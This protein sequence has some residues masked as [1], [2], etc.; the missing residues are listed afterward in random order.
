MPDAQVDPGPILLVGAGW[1]G[2]PLAI[3][4]K[5]LGRKIVVT[6]RRQERI[7]ALQANGLSC[8]RLDLD[9]SGE[10]MGLSDR[11][12]PFQTIIWAV[13]PG[14]SSG[15]SYAAQL[16]LLLQNWPAQSARKLVFYS[17]TGVYPESAGVWN[18]KS[19]VQTA[20]RVAEA[21]EM[22]KKWGG[23]LLLL[24]CGGLCDEKRVIGR[25]FSGKALPNAGQPVNYI[26]R[27]DVIGATLHL[28][29]S[30]ATGTYN[31]V[32]PEHPTRFGVFEAQAKRY[33]FA[34]PTDLLE[35]G[36]E[37]LIGVDKLLE[38][39]YCFLNPDPKT[40]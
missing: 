4:L 12:A 34:P 20:H 35:G 16:E 6:A 26:H 40:F 3:H 25:Y 28:L 14:K 18:E 22:A 19:D 31:L 11:I 17:S 21:E 37:R 2:E 33:G 7:I 10:N 5:Q 38:S 36:V 13:P 30:L 8:W 32:A 15:K 1:L 27:E 9:D 23:E 24:R 29:N 39:G